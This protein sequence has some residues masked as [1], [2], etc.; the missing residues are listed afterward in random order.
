MNS[1]RSQR[2][3]ISI[4]GILSLVILLLIIFVGVKIVPP[5]ISNYQLQNSI[6]NI[7]L[8]ASYSPITEDEI[9]RN[10]LSQAD[11]CGI[12]LQPNQVMVKKGRGTVVIVV[13]YTVTV[14]F[15]V[16][17]MDIHFEPSTSNQNILMK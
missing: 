6:Q 17:K 2:G 11:S 15:I 7:A 9:H 8:I 13:N 5:Y 12:D 3:F 16:R 10:V 14:D 1:E 4:S